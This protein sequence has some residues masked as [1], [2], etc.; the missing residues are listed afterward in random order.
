MRFGRRRMTPAIE[1][2]RE[3][4]GVQ[5]VRGVDVSDH[6]SRWSATRA[7]SAAAS[8]AGI[9]GVS[10]EVITFRARDWRSAGGRVRRPC[11]PRRVDRTH[12]SDAIPAGIEDD[13]VPGA[14][15]RIIGRLLSDVP[16][17][18]EFLVERIDFRRVAEPAKELAMAQRYFLY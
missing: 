5:T 15:E 18:R 12:Q 2:P 14:P 7:V 10:R 17:A 6:R 8:A 16:G 4:F 1:E 3:L 9:R 11:A 13:C